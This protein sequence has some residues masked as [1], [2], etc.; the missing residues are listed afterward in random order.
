MQGKAHDPELRQQV[1][2]ALLAGQGVREV[3]RQYQLS[4]GLVHAWR[5]TLP[6]EQLERLRTEKADL[7]GEL[8]SGYLT[9]VVT[10][11]RV[12]AE[13]FRDGKW[14]AAQPASEAAVL[15]GVLTDKAIRLLEAAELAEREGEPDE[16]P[17]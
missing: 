13:F 16:A 9:E 15:H 14:L 1:I 6:Q 8:L 12:Q 11:L 7:I 4:P 10:T 2:A 5:Q 17:G 3:A